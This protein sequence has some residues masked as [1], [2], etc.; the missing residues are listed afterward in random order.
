MSKGAFNNVSVWASRHIAHRYN[1]LAMQGEG[2]SKLHIDILADSWQA[3][4]SLCSTKQ[5]EP[6][7]KYNK[8]SAELLALTHKSRGW[9]GQH[10][11]WLRSHKQV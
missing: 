6:V 8:T 10:F 5:R 9:L 3:P 11:L 1:K 7:F 2:K 4:P